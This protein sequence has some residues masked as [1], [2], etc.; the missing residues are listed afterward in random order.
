MTIRCPQ[1]ELENPDTASLCARCA[2]P[3]AGE[4]LVQTRVVPP[5]SQATLTA[6]GR[7]A[8]D[9]LPDGSDLG[10]R[11]QII[12]L[13]GR[14]GMGAVYLARD[15]ELGRE[16]AIKVI[17]TQLIDDI[18]SIDRFKRE[19]RLSSLVTHPNVLRVYDFSEADGTKFLTMQFVE[20][21]SLDVVL[22]EDQPLPLDRAIALFRQICEGLAAAHEQGVLHRDMKPQ[23]VMVDG[24]DRV[25]LTDFG[26]ATSQFVTAMTQTGGLLGTPHYMSPEQVRSEQVDARSD[27]FSLGLVF[28]QMLTGALPYTGD[29]VYELMIKRT[30]SPPPPAREINPSI[31]ANLAGVLDRCLAIDKAQRYAAVRDII[32]DLDSGI[33]R[34]PVA[35]P[36]ARPRARR[37]WP[38]LAAVGLVLMAAAGGTWAYLQSRPGGTAKATEAAVSVPMVGVVPFANRTGDTSLDW[39]GEGVA[40]LVADSLALSRHVRVVSPQRMAG[41]RSGA[42][43]DAA[44]FK[45]SSDSGIAYLLT[46]EILIGPKGFTVATRLTDARSGT[47]V[48]SN[49]VEGASK[50]DVIGASNQVAAAA[51]RG[52]RIPLTEQVDT[53]NA[54]FATEN[55]EAYEIYVKGLNA[56]SF[57]KYE[58]AVR[59]FTAALEKAP[60]FTMARFRLANAYASMGETEEATEQINVALA[61]ASRLPD[62]EGRYIRALDAIIARR[63]DDAVKQYKELVDR[64]PYDLEPRQFLAQLYLESQQWRE[65]IDQA[66]AMA[67]IDPQSHSTYAVLGSAYLGLKEYNQAIKEFKTYSDLEPG[68]AN[69][70]HLLADAYRAQGV[71]DLAAGEYRKALAADPAFHYSTVSL[72]EVEAVRGQADEAERL[73]EPLV[74]DATANPSRRAD[75]A[76][77]LAAIRRAQGRFRDAIG[78]LEQARPPI[79][80][81]KIREALKASTQAMCYLELGEL[82]RAEALAREAIKKSPGVPTRYLF[83]LAQVQLAQGKLADARAT[84][85]EILKGALPPSDPDRTEDKAAAYIRGLALLREGKAAQAQEELSRAV[86]LSGYEYSVYRLGLAR[87]YLQAG[88]HAEALA[89]VKEASAPGNPADP[90]LDL[91]LDRV[92]AGLVEAEVNVALER[93]AEAASAAKQFLQAWTRADPGLSDVAQARRLAGLQ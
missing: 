8:G 88:A 1:C 5:E 23:N 66:N 18:G 31:P 11:Y 6:G 44:F 74:L 53:F 65:A 68:S 45:T 29:S 76:F 36:A 55:S 86:A 67:Q 57:Y 15:R 47:D 3:L 84:A 49:R 50:A 70:H 72:A 81:E 39:A 35:A 78:T 71:A 21:R 17:A 32:V 82:K 40:R 10:P 25:Y 90:R 80:S 54:D 12:R 46:G 62:R 59:L 60:D 34:E 79:Q 91:N 83:S 75:A 16:V 20:G 52:L 73:L 26:L 85:T 51:R 14:G 93:R 22:R 13:L 64:Y 63:T 37:R 69:A 42:K 30:Q 43:D 24:A 77:D 41:L 87:A 61:E 56:V 33:V 7:A 89:S 92:R 9:A 2:T 27:I 38:V 4:T 48:A 58:D 28:Y 19:I